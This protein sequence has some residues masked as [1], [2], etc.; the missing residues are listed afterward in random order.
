VTRELSHIPIYEGK[1][2][3]K[4]HWFICERFWDANDI[5]D[6]VKQMEQFGP[7]QVHE[8]H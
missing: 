3:P 5:I 8:F 7:H 4:H 2:D 6:E 1:E